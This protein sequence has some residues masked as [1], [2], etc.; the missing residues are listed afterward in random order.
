[1]KNKHRTLVL[2]TV[3]AAF[4]CWIVDAVAQTNTAGSTTTGVSGDASQLTLIQG[5][6]P[7]LVPFVIALIKKVIPIVPKALLPL[8]APVIG[9]ASDYLLQQSGLAPVGG[10]AVGAILGASGVM[11][12]EGANQAL[13]AA[14]LIE[15]KPKDSP[16]VVSGE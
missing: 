11:V 5:L 12:R 16:L 6:I 8:L 2:L 14:G 13:K 15:D 7:L 3:L 1:M 9:V 4:I 10:L